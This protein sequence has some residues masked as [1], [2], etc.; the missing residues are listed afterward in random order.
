MDSPL[1]RK[2]DVRSLTLRLDVLLEHCEGV[3]SA[4]LLL[5]YDLLLLQMAVRTAEVL[6]SH[7]TE[8][9]HILLMFECWLLS[10]Q[11]DSTLTVNCR[12]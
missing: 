1:T 3:S 9:L 8:R 6:E 5:D 4:V 2:P 7:F 10:V 11:Y 12:L